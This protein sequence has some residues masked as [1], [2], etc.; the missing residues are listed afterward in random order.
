MRKIFTFLLLSGLMLC[1]SA[2]ANSSTRVYFVNNS[3]WSVV[4]CYAWNEPGGDGY[5]NAEFPGVDITTQKMDMQVAGY[6]VYYYDVE[7]YAN[8]KFSNG[9]A[10]SNNF[11]VSEG[12]YCYNG[13][14]S[15]S[16]MYLRGTMNGWD[17]SMEMS[18]ISANIWAISFSATTTS[19]NFK[20]DS[21]NWTDYENF[22]GVE[23][24]ANVQT[25]VYALGPGGA[26][27]TISVSSGQKYYF[28][29]DI[30]STKYAEVATP[31]SISYDKNGG[32]G[33]APVD[34]GEYY[35]DYKYPLAKAHSITAPANKYFAGWNSEDDGNGTD[36]AVGD[37]V[38][39]SADITL[40][41]QWESY[42]HVTYDANGGSGAVPTD[43]NNYRQGDNATVLGKGS[44][45]K[46]GYQFKCW[47][48]Q[49]DG[50]GTDYYEDDLLPIGA[51]SVTLYAK[52]D[53]IVATHFRYIG[54]NTEAWA[55]SPTNKILAYT[56][57]DSN[58]SQNNGWAGK[59]TT[60]N[61]GWVDFNLNNSE[62]DRILFDNGSGGDGNQTADITID[63]TKDD[64]YITYDGYAKGNTTTVSNY[65][66]VTFTADGYA[67]LCA[68]FPVAIPSGITVYSVAYTEG[69]ATALLREEADLTSNGVPANTGVIL[70][71][72][73]G[74]VNLN[75]QLTAGTLA[76]TNDLLG[77]LVYTTKSDYTYVLGRV[78]NVTGFYKYT[79]TNIPANRAYL[80]SASAVSAPMVVRFVEDENG[81][82]NINAVDASEE[83]VKFLQNGKLFIQKNGVVYDMMGAIV[84]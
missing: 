51:T 4:K 15:Y 73:S 35:H 69:A 68:P 44:I 28:I 66:P 6:D 36:Y 30:R 81:A 80:Y 45:A 65:I 49:D 61:D 7:G 46:D 29:L 40:F 57:L 19:Y 10:E 16:N 76:N 83:A 78:E 17:K 11:T 70:K 72:G 52:W 82:T 75:Y 32:T 48:T 14:C 18:A 24:T 20:Y 33:D 53:R 3:N 59:A 5:Q 38:N 60:P 8:C 43:A 50:E 41:A 39:V 62:Y 2:W 58:T 25:L 67:S 64:V 23:L 1:T 22:G 55:I 13:N 79:G 84:K 77:T 37:P 34:G 27:T 54:A 26:N 21:G 31:F 12:L 63:G 9:S 71:G 42:R 74:T 47:N 56:W